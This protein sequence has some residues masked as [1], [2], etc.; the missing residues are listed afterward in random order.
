M[1]TGLAPAKV[2]VRLVVFGQKKKT[3]RARL[4]RFSLRSLGVVLPISISKN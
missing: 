4:Y 2:F 1:T 3:Q